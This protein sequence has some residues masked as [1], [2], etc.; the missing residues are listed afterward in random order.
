[1][2]TKKSMA[3]GLVGRIPLKVV[4]LKD[5]GPLYLLYNHSP[6]TSE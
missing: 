2:R 5:F 6:F 1:M 3:S 4:C